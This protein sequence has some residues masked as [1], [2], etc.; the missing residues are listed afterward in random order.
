MSLTL[1]YERVRSLS[2]I[3]LA[4]KCVILSVAERFNGVALSSSSSLREK[5]AGRWILFC[6]KEQERV[7]TGRSSWLRSVALSCIYVVS[8]VRSGLFDLE[9]IS[10]DSW[11]SMCSVHEESSSDSSLLWVKLLLDNIDKTVS[12]RLFTVKSNQL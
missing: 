12:R 4:E 5:Q 3:V 1:D 11:M 10:S 8:R 9:P 7:E 2:K 6:R